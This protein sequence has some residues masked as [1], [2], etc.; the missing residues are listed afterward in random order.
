MNNI[1][2]FLSETRQAVL[3]TELEKLRK[4]DQSIL[5]NSLYCLE[6]EKD[7]S[8][9]LN[10]FLTKKALSE[11]NSFENCSRLLNRSIHALH[12]NIYILSVT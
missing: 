7:L 10:H 8:N 6:W 11:S 4:L 3:I 12:S 5:N 9:I 2:Q 1:Y